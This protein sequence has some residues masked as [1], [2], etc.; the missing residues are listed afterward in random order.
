MLTIY[1][2]HAPLIRPV[3]RPASDDHSLRDKNLQQGLTLNGAI[4]HYPDVTLC[5]QSGAI[6]LLATKGGERYSADSDAKVKF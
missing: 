5:L 2:H 6:V 4:K 3:Y 1:D